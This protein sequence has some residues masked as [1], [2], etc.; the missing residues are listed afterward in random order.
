MVWDFFFDWWGFFLDRSYVQYF[1]PKQGQ[2]QNIA[3]VL[4]DCE[5]E[6]EEL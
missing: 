1:L 3:P 6:E 2:W 4:Q 5:I